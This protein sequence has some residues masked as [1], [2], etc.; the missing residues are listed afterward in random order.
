MLKQNKYEE[1]LKWFKDRVGKVV[2]RNDNG[3]PCE[4]CKHVVENGLIITDELHADYLCSTQ[5]DYAAEGILL[6]YRDEK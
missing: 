6:N 4:I 1:R 2:F 5:G 3:C